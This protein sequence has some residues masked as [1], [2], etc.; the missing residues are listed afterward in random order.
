MFA[1]YSIGDTG[2]G[3]TWLLWDSYIDLAVPH[4]GTNSGNVR[5]SIAVGAVSG[6]YIIG[7]L[8]ASSTGVPSGSRDLG[9]G[10]GWGGGGGGGGEILPTDKQTDRAGA[11]VVDGV[12]VGD[13]CDRSWRGRGGGGTGD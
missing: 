10:R 9:R 6:F 12:E 13:G 7:P 2:D 11:A 3:D 8:R 5:A 1:K 4:T